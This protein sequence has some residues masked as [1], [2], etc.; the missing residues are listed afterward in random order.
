MWMY[1]IRFLLSHLK[2]KMRSKISL[3]IVPYPTKRGMHSTKF[4]A[5]W[6]I[7]DINSIWLSWWMGTVLS[8]ATDDSLL[9]REKWS[10]SIKSSTKCRCAVGM[11]Q[12]YPS[13]K[14][15]RSL[16][17]NF[18]QKGSGCLLK[19]GR[20][21]WRGSNPPQ[22]QQ[23]PE[24]EERASEMMTEAG[25]RVWS[26]N[27]VRCG[28]LDTLLGCRFANLESI[29]HAFLRAFGNTRH[30]WRA[31]NV[32]EMQDWRPLGGPHWKIKWAFFSNFMRELN[33]CSQV[34]SFP[35]Q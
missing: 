12:V 5:P 14:R 25:P 3:A 22:S 16:H 10:L 13:P 34:F 33:L 26:S 2:R 30:P 27:L 28:D 6:P 23:P 15:G 17:K 1:E 32:Q 31:N 19:R 24:H 21:W 7:S 11:A 35:Q 20:K 8:F 4:R 9:N 18:E 29:E